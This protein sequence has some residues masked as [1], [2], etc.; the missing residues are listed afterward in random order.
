[1]GKMKTCL[2]VAAWVGVGIIALG[3]P[4]AFSSSETIVNWGSTAGFGFQLALIMAIPSTLLVLTGGFI[5]KPRYLWIGAIVVG[6]AYISSFYGVFLAPLP[7]ETNEL[8]R[9]LPL[10]LLLLSPGLACIIGGIVMQRVQAS[11]GR[12]SGNFSNERQ[13]VANEKELKLE[14]DAVYKMKVRKNDRSQESNEEV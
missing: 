7:V 13:V 1:M 4:L 8:L 2:K 9:G 3:T 6:L 12:E 10:L 11:S 14:P 5:A